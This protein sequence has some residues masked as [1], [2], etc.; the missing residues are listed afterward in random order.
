MGLNDLEQYQK[1]ALVTGIIAIAIV[2]FVCRYYA[3]TISEELR[4]IDDAA[5]KTYKRELE[6]VNAEIK[7]EE[8]ELN[9]RLKLMADQ[10]AREAEEERKA[11]ETIAAAE[12]ASR[13]ASEKAKIEDE[14][15]RKE[16]EA[17]LAAAKAIGAQV[18]TKS[19][20]LD[21]RSIGEFRK[22]VGKKFYIISMTDNKYLVDSNGK[23]NGGGPIHLC[24]FF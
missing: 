23:Q 16:I 8:D 10:R 5:Y 4:A 1:I 24:L 20:D 21:D 18:V 15:R 12:E 11:Q 2:C 13:I 14:R 22:F 6:R 3:I 19:V 7:V 9:E 17:K